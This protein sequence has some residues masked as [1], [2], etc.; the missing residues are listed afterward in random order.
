MHVAILVRLDGTVKAAYGPYP[1]AQAAFVALGITNKRTQELALNS[2]VEY[3]G[4]ASRIAVRE[5]TPENERR[6]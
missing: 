3:N 5:L 1:D 6:A 4:S 2:S